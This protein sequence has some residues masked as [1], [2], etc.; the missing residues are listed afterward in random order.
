MTLP[1]D[2][3]TEALAE[4]RR[5]WLRLFQATPPYTLHT[6]PYYPGWDPAEHDSDVRVVIDSDGRRRAL[7][8]TV[9]R[10][11]RVIRKARKS[12]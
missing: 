10:T 9:V 12:G 5:L 3:A 7:K 8:P 1:Q 4:E 6:L 2:A 11:E